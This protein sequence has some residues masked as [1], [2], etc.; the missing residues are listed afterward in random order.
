MIDISKPGDDDEQ[1]GTGPSGGRRGAKARKRRVS[2]TD[3]A[4]TDEGVDE[5][6]DTVDDDI[7]DID[8][9]AENADGEEVPSPG[10]PGRR[11]TGGMFRAGCLVLT[12]FG[13]LLL[14]QVGPAVLDP[15]AAQCEGARAAIDTANDDDEDF[16]DVELDDRD[17]DDLECAEAVTLAGGIPADEDDEP[18]GEF[19]KASTIR[20]QSLILS[21]LSIGLGVS[22]FLTLRTKARRARTFALVS[23]VVL[24]LLGPIGL[25][26]GMFA[27]YALVFS[28]DA[29]AIF[30]EP[31]GLGG[32]MRPRPPR[33]A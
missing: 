4:P 29:R 28:A 13:V 15:E 5:L 11:S 3:P 31:R 9:G 26:A 22:G 2:P 23:C 20:T 21:A 32:M 8:E 14:I 12:A 17:V 10:R 18:D 1:A 30:G 6:D 19:V 27:V 25:I 7:D 33:A 16:N 24:L